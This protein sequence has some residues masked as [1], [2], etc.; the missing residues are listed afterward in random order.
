MKAE[1]ISVSNDFLNGKRSDQNAAFLTRCFATLG[2]KVNRSTFVDD[3]KEKLKAVL[4]VAEEEAELIVLVGGLGPDETDITKQ[5]ISEHLDV[6]LVLDQAT[7][8]EIITYHN[9]SQFVMPQNNQM[10]AMILFDS[11]PIHNETG[12]AVGMFYKGNKNS[13]LLLPGPFNELKP[14]YEKVA[15]PII[16]DAFF[17]NIH[18]ETR[19]LRIF[20]ISETELTL[21]L[22][23]Y[24][25]YEGSPLV[26]IYKEGHEL[27]V[28]ITV[29]SKN[30]DQAA[31]EADNLK[32]EITDYIKKYVYAEKREKLVKTVKDLLQKND[33]KVTAA[34]SLTG[35]EFLSA[36]S[37]QEEASEVLSGGMVTYSTEIKN[38]VL[39]VPKELTDEY[40]V[41][42][43][44]CAISMAENAKDMFGADIGVSL[45]GVAGPASLEG[46]IPGTVWIGIASHNQET[47]AKK[48]HFAYKRNENRTLSILAAMNLVRLVILEEEIEDTVTKEHENPDDQEGEEYR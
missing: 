27:E 24:L 38:N 31:E 25:D 43:A 5:T 4:Q 17:K 23:K 26:G 41:V 6:P 8:D 14:T 2:I 48:F 32:K 3:S 18:I 13:Y 36:F 37:S 20:G 12:L 16:K 11:I 40:G 28:Q 47:F 29:R 10:Q 39:G 35:G 9:N 33:L 45:T 44:E 46:E 1:I 34:E 30:K 15:A 42:S 7:E 21:T 19:F 22:K